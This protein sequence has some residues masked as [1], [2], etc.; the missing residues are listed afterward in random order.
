MTIK[1]RKMISKS[2]QA[3]LYHIPEDTVDSV[4]TQALSAALQIFMEYVKGKDEQV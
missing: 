3:A 4:E 2:E 1:M